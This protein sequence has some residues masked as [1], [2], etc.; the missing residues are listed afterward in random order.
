MSLNRKAILSVSLIAAAV[1]GWWLFIRDPLSVSHCI[2]HPERFQ[3][4]ADVNGQPI[5]KEIGMNALLPIR[6]RCPMPSG[7]DQKSEFDAY[8]YVVNPHTYRNADVIEA[9]RQRYGSPRVTWTINGPVNG[10]LEPPLPAKDENVLQFSSL[11]QGKGLDHAKRGVPLELHLWLYPVKTLP[12][13][14]KQVSQ[15]GE[16]VFRHA[17]QFVDDSSSK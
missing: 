10:N 11:L 14:K 8:L 16:W 9:F 3:V 15:T 7:L 17:F 4:S 2:F 6:F 12:H 1:C 13:G 5:P